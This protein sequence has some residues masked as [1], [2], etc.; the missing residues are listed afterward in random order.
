MLERDGFV[1]CYELSSDRL[2]LRLF[3][4]FTLGRISLR[5]VVYVRQR[6]ADDLAQLVRDM[7]LK[8][9][10]SW[11]WPHPAMS[12]RSGH[13]TPYVI[14]TQGGTRIFVRLRSGFHYRL[15]A[16]IGDAKAAANGASRNSMRS[17]SEVSAAAL[18]E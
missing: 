6:G 17:S 14:R 3:R 4:L 8:P 16:A 11:Y 5:N 10:R 15:R 13:S 1:W 7:F 2:R 18:S 9:F 12:Y